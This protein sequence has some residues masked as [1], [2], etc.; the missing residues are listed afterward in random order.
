MR[1]AERDDDDDKKEREGRT[2]EGNTHKR[3]CLVAHLHFAIKA[4]LG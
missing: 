4:S 1:K 3:K 2:D